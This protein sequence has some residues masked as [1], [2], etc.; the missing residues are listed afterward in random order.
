[1]APV[2]DA[3][4]AFSRLRASEIAS[5]EALLACA[6]WASGFAS[7]RTFIAARIGDGFGASFAEAASAASMALACR[8]S[9]LTAFALASL[10]AIG[11]ISFCF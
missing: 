8:L 11:L 10:H 7:D 5:I 9:C 6:C 3:D 4:L 2:H 1:M